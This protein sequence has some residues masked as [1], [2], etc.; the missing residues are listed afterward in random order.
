MHMCVLGACTSAQHQAT[1]NPLLWGVNL[2]RPLDLLAFQMQPNC[3]EKIRKAHRRVSRKGQEDTGKAAQ[4]NCTKTA[5]L[6][7]LERFGLGT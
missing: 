2:S 5:Q 6:K 1:E 7:E 3:V 4:V